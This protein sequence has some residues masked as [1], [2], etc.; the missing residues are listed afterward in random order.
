MCSFT[1]NVVGGKQKE[2]RQNGK[3]SVAIFL[4]YSTYSKTLP[5]GPP[6][7]LVQMVGLAGRSD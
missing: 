6:L 3:T 7:G 1:R 4:C 2:V 5:I